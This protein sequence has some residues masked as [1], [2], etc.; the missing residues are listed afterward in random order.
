MKCVGKSFQK[1]KIINKYRSTKNV[2]F[3]VWTLAHH[4]SN[5]R[6]FVYSDKPYA[7][8]YQRYE[9]CVKYLC[10]CVWVCEYLSISAY[11]IYRYS[12]LYPLRKSLS[13]HDVHYRYEWMS[14][15]HPATVESKT[16]QY[17]IYGLVWNCCKMTSICVKVSVTLR[18][19][20]IFWQE[21]CFRMTVTD[22]K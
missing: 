18:Y 10:V 13:P 5:L 1:K 4:T 19:N 12:F 17:L 3:I 20:F 8:V 2:T 21:N 11:R 7:N 6:I 22:T 14:M 16:K 9:L 15:P